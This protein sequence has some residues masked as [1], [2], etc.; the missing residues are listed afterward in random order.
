MQVQHRILTLCV[1]HFTVG[2]GAQFGAQLRLCRHASAKL[3][4]LGVRARAALLS[5]LQAE[6]PAKAPHA[7][8]ATLFIGTEE[9]CRSDARAACLRSA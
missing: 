4:A 7:H 9:P 1:Q 3:S 2:A 5:A 8:A 6:R